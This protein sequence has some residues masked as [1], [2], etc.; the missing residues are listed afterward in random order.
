MN[1][2][3]DEVGHLAIFGMAPTVV[4]D[5]QIRRI[6]WQEF[7][8][9]AR[10]IQVA[11]Q[12]RS[13]LMPAEAVPD[14]EQGTLEMPPELLDKAQDISAREIPRGDGKI[15]AQALLLGGD[16][17]CTRHG[18]AVMTVPTIMDG[19]VPLG[20][21]GAAHRGLKHEACLINKNDGAALTPGFF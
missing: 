21:P 16:G 18:E 1:I 7:H 8:M 11:Q 9:D 5:V 13:F 19:C 20:G 17:N 3:G 14:H 15:E 2:M 12:S 6:S 4:D 10:A